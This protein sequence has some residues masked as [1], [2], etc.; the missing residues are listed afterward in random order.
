MKSIVKKVE[1]S[2]RSQTKHKALK[3]IPHCKNKQDKMT[4]S[5]NDADTTHHILLDLLSQQHHTWETTAVA[6]LNLRICNR[7]RER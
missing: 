1:A 7:D 6:S 2:E 3:T 5:V 4:H